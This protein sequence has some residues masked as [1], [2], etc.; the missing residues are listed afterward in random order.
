ML[1]PGLAR[2]AA[3]DPDIRPGEVR[4]R[5]DRDTRLC[6]GAATTCEVVSRK[7]LVDALKASYLITQILKTNEIGSEV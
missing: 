3:S 7:A 4:T 1:F 5:C 2:D 6:S